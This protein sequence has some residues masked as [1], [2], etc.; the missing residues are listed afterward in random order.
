MDDA[1][2]GT[3]TGEIISAIVARILRAKDRPAAGRL[4]NLREAGL[5]SLELVNVMLAVEDAFELTLPQEAMTPENFRSIAAIEALV[6]S[7]IRP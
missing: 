2:A 6:V 4:D 3:G 7:L 5:T 1:Q